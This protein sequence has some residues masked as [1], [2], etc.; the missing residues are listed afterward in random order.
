MTYFPSRF[1]SC[2]AL[3]SRS[4]RSS[5]RVS[6]WIASQQFSTST[7]RTSFNR[8]LTAAGG[9]MPLLWLHFHPS[10][11]ELN[12]A[13]HWFPSMGIVHL[14]PVLNLPR[15]L[16]VYH[17]VTRSCFHL[18]FLKRKTL[19]IITSI[20]KKRTLEFISFSEALWKYLLFLLNC[21]NQWIWQK[22]HW[23]P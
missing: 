13:D 10:K 6:C 4:I 8:L 23:R 17:A 2:S 16:A 14:S 5:S 3:L 20:R 1:N 7:I 18:S 15:S 12:G 11:W 21:W 19:L 9:F 22:V